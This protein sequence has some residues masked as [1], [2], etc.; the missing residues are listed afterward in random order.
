MAVLEHGTAS[1]SVSIAA[2]K[3]IANVLQERKEEVGDS[4][5]LGRLGHFVVSFVCRV[6]ESIHK[7]ESKL[8]AGNVTSWINVCV[9]SLSLLR[10]LQSSSGLF[11]DAS[12]GTSATTTVKP[13]T[14]A[15]RMD[16]LGRLD[17]DAEF[18]RGNQAI[19]DQDQH[20]KYRQQVMDCAGYFTGRE[21]NY[22]MAILA[23]VRDSLLEGAV[24]SGVALLC[25]LPVP[26]R[27][28]V[29]AWFRRCIAI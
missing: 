24:P 3:L 19:L 21:D 4:V 23:V 26:S 29:C 18:G 11:M 17:S 14:Q 22:A 20:A 7:T 1:T 13:T 27:F 25:S 15:T 6:M 5:F 16:T 9:D 8:D 10:N 28:F 2:I 12:K